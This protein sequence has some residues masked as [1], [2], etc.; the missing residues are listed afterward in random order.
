VRLQFGPK[1][2]YR[3]EHTLQFYEWECTPAVDAI[4][5][6][7]YL[8]D[9]YAPNL[10]KSVDE[11]F[12]TQGHVSTEIPPTAT[13]ILQTPDI[14]AH[15]PM[16]RIYQQMEMADA[17]IQLRRGETMPSTSRNTVMARAISCYEQLD[18]DRV[19]LGFLDAGIANDLH[20][21]QDDKISS[22]VRPFWDANDMHSRR[23]Q[24]RDWVKARVDSKEFVNF[25]ASVRSQGFLTP[26]PG[27]YTSL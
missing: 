18:H 20:G 3:L 11:F 23:L 5:S 25:G 2:S 6:S 14:R 26:Y 4:D 12:E 7:L 15:G 10:D 16:E 13:G 9:Y 27:C 19:S 17:Q 21:T 8:H 1:G 22:E 24:I